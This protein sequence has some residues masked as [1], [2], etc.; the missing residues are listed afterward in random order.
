[1]HL[2][3]GHLIALAYV[4]RYISVQLHRRFLNFGSFDRGAGRGL[5]FFAFISSLLPLL[6]DCEENAIE[7]IRFRMLRFIG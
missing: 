6:I 2:Q 1:M 7:E 5:G 4:I 3:L